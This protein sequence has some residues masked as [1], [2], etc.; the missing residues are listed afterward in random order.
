MIK[1]ISIFFSSSQIELHST[2]TCLDDQ[3]TA[4]TTPERIS[5]SFTHEQLKDALSSFVLLNM[6]NKQTQLVLCS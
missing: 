2:D 1:S 4:K 3:L 6:I 5:R